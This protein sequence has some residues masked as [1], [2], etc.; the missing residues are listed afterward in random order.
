MGLAP[1]RQR[2]HHLE[3]AAGAVD[4]APGRPGAD[5]VRAV[6]GVA[7]EEVGEVTERGE[8]TRSAGGVHG[9]VGAAQVGSEGVQPGLVQAGVDDLEQRPD[10]RLGQPRVGI[11]LDARRGRDRI[12]DEP[13]RRG[14][15]HV[16]A[17]PVAPAGRRAEPVGHPLGQ[18]A[19]HPPRGHA[20]DVGREG[21]RP[22]AGPA[23]AQR[24]DQPVGAF[25]SVD[26]QHG[27]SVRR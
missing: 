8:P 18:P 3:L 12:A 20:H 25:G 24:L 13:A 27:D 19:H 6:Q 14:E 26:V 15:R 21:I 2:A 22:A 17:H 4:V 7:V 11:G 1:R 16:G 5:H 23:A 9:P 10:R